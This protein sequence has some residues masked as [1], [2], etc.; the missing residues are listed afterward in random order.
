[1][2]YGASIGA[3]SIVICGLTIGEF[4]LVGAGSVVT[5]N[6]SPHA[7]VFGA[8]I[9]RDILFE[10]ERIKTFYCDQ[11]DC[12]QLRINCGSQQRGVPA[13]ATQKPLIIGGRP[14]RPRLPPSLTGVRW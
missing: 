14:L 13:A 12:D 9:D 5:R 6:V 10:D 2:K 8:D 11:L 3:G 1:V 4:A 7:L